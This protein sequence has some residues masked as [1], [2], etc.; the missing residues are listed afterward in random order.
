MVMAF[1]SVNVPV[2]QFVAGCFAH[3]CNR[4]AEHKRLPGQRMIAINNNAIICDVCDGI[5]DVLLRTLWCAF[6]LHA[7]R[8]ILRETLARLHVH[9]L[10]VIITERFVRFH[11]D[12]ASIS[13]LLSVENAF[14]NR[15]DPAISAV[16]VTYR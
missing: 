10:L 5:D 15:E 8:Q 12:F 4:A 11:Q 13:N 1:R 9:Q 16:K 2:F 14:D 7:N 3:F 6:K